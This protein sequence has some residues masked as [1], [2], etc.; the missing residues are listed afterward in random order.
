ME[1]F[2]PLPYGSTSSL[3]IALVVSSKTPLLLLDSDLIV[4]AV[5]ES[6]C[7]DFEVDCA[8]IPGKECFAI[9]G[10]EWDVPQLRSLLRTTVAGHSAIDA[11]EMDLERRGRPLARLV[12]NAH[13][14]KAD[15]SDKLWIVLAIQ[16]V[17]EARLLARQKAD[18]IR[19]KDILLEEVQH[20]VANSLQIIA[21]VLMQSARSVKSLESR[22]H[23]KDAHHRVMSVATLQRQLAQTRSGDVAIRTYF[24]DLCASISASMISKEDDLTLAASVD[25]SVTDADVSVSLGLIV[26]ELV[27]NALKHA[28]P[29]NPKTGKIVVGYKSDGATWELRVSDNGVGMP[30]PSEMPKVGLGTGII[31]ALAGQLDGRLVVAPGNP[32]TIITIASAEHVALTP[33]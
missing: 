2:T 17:T 25:D 3:G 23:L 1:F 5:S 33:A 28:F 14:L 19:E 7:V 6:F 21:S 26:T 4:R 18:L 30:L 27:I 9:G 15:D 29:G 20:R 13:A 11:Y 10:G 24:T 12:L 32:G 8:D 16:N 31:E 22:M